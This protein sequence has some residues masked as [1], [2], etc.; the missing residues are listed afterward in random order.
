MDGV[1]SHRQV[2]AYPN[3][4]HMQLVSTVALMMHGLNLAMLKSKLNSISIF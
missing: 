1:G 2:V 3:K 4:M